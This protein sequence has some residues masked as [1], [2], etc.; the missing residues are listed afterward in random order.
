MPLIPDENPP[1][2]YI[3]EYTGDDTCQRGL[4]FFIAINKLWL[5][6]ST[7]PSLEQVQGWHCTTGNSGLFGVSLTI[8]VSLTL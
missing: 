2:K 1:I 7:V 5:S 4:G 6:N 8:R 3:Q